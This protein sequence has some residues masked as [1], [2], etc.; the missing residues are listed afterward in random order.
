[1]EP[2]KGFDL[3]R[4]RDVVVSLRANGCDNDGRTRTFLE[5][6]GGSNNLKNR[7]REG[8]AVLLLRVGVG[9]ESNEGKRVILLLVL[10]SQW[11]E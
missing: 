3:V 5:Q 10:L 11:T 7:E 9:F 1:L 2:R 4:G 6:K 8:N